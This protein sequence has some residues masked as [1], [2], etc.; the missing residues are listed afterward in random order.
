M[1]SVEEAI[2]E[3]WKLRWQLQSAP[4]TCGYELEL[5]ALGFQKTADEA[6][7]IIFES[8]DGQGDDAKTRY[9]DLVLLLKTLSETELGILGFLCCGN[10]GWEPYQKVVPT[11]AL[12]DMAVD[13]GDEDGECKGQLKNG[14]LCKRHRQRGFARC[15][16]HADQESAPVTK[17]TDS[18]EELLSIS[19]LN[20]NMAVVQGVRVR[21]PTIAETADYIGVTE[22]QLR[23]YVFNARLKVAER[24]DRVNA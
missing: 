4:S 15:K 1:P 24:L 19:E 12:K 21:R 11:Y 14:G 23:A 8:D 20:D 9:G 6:L 13:F 16:T 18:G 22:T 3:Y 2:T 10:A 7:G 17:I 5:L